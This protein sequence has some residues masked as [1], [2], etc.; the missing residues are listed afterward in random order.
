MT[1]PALGAGDNS[2]IAGP[3]LV[4]GVGLV[5]GSVA[6]A[7]REAG[8]GPLWGADVTPEGPPG[9]F[10]RWAVSPSAELTQLCEAARLIILATPISVTEALLPSLMTVSAVV[11]DCG[12]AKRSIE[13]TVER[14]QAAH[15]SSVNMTS[16]GSAEGALSASGELTSGPAEGA[17]SAPVELTNSRA[18]SALTGFVGG[19]PMAGRE[20]GGFEHATATL[21]Q[22]RSWFIC[23]APRSSARSVALVE[24]LVATLG[25]VPVRVS[26]EHH[27]R[28]VAL[29]SHL[30]QVVAS[31]LVAVAG[32]A[33][34]FAGPAFEGA[35]RVA[36][37][38]EAIWRDI[39]TA[40]SAEL[41]GA[42]QA[43]ETTLAQARHGLT[44][45]DVEPLLE[46]LRVAR[47]LKRRSD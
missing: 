43:M 32:G 24:R 27:D 2:S 37:G 36:G 40:N 23:R 15:S 25:A 5:G 20:R 1:S 46:L 39:F 12:S 17:L 26:A 10:E 30:T 47:E 13:R 21:F 6:L 8:V 29:T 18:E 19:H 28:Q 3:V 38:P 41:L 9:V 34:Q 22:G 16:G 31:A 33:E 14:L 35:T 42:L 4:V 7:L 45:G 11:T 44:S